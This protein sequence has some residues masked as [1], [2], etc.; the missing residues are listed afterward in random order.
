MTT[1]VAVKICNEEQS[2]I[3]KFLL[4]DEPFTVS[5][6]DPALQAMVNNTIEN[7]KGVVEDVL[8]KIKFTW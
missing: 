4:H 8:V 5:K 1:E 2:Y 7:F 6:D 3:Q